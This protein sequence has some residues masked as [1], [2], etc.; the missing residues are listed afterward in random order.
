MNGDE[1]QSPVNQ[2]GNIITGGIRAVGDYK[3]ESYRESQLFAQESQQ[4]ESARA[5]EDERK[6]WWSVGLS[7]LGSLFGPIGVPIGMAVGKIVGELGTVGGKQ[8][9]DYLVSTDVGKFEKQQK[10]T[11]EEFNRNLKTYDKSQLWTD[12]MDIGK[13]GLFAYKGG[14]SL[15]GGPASFSPTKWG[16]TEGTTSMDFLNDAWKRLLPNKE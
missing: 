3:Q 13:A 2:P 12:I 7:L 9:E 4:A 14:T 5:I 1:Y 6:L 16:G 11:L 10:F 8:A 15:K